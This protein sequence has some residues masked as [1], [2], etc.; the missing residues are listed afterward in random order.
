MSY[1]RLFPASRVS[2]VGSGSRLSALVVLLSLC[3]AGSAQAQRVVSQ[4]E[5]VVSVSKGGS[6]LLVNPVPLSRRP[7]RPAP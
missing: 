6:A 2:R 7:G 3:A 1:D 4:A 5:R